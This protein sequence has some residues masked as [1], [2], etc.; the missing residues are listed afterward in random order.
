MGKGL[1]KFLD[2]KHFSL[3]SCVCAFQ[4]VYQNREVQLLYLKVFIFLWVQI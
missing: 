3:E 4:T 1:F 2:I